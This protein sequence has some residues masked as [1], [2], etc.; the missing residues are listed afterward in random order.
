M[1]R[2]PFWARVH[3]DQTAAGH[4]EALIELQ[5]LLAEIEDH[6]SPVRPRRP[7]HKRLQV[8]AEIIG[9]AIGLLDAGR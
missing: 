3:A 6:V 9:D 4:R 8:W 5:G 1:T 2:E 7:G